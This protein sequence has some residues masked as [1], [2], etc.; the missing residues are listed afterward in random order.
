MTPELEEKYNKSEN[1]ILNISA[2]FK[3]KFIKQAS[4][5]I[6]FFQIG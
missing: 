4:K 6:F 5:K 3:I 1:A 2:I